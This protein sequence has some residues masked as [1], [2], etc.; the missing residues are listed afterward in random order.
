MRQLISVFSSLVVTTC[1]PPP[2]PVAWETCLVYVCSA[3]RLHTAVSG[4]LL[5]VP[6]AWTCRQFGATDP[7]ITVT[8]ARRRY[9]IQLVEPPSTYAVLVRQ[10]PRTTRTHTLEHVRKRIPLSSPL[11]CW[12]CCPAHRRYPCMIALWLSL[13]FHCVTACLRRLRLRYS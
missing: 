2:D 8:F 5:P 1:C 4:G 12:W 10:S 7:Q 9:A 13:L 3:L 11:R 6:L